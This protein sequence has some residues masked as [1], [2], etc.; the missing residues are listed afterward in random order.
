MGNYVLYEA[1]DDIATLTLN[2]PEKLNPI[3]IPLQEELR[4]ALARL[5]DDR[6]IRCAILTGAGRAFCVGADLS[7]MGADPS[8]QRSRGERS[9]DMMTRISNPIIMALRQLSVPVVAAVNGPAAGAGVGIALACDLVVA[10][11]SAYFYLPFM[12]RLGIIPDLG[13]TWFLPRLVGSARAMGMSL[14]G[15]RLTAEQAAAW[16]LIWSCV[17][18]E[19]LP[20]EAHTL[21]RRLAALPVHAVTE[22]RAALAASATNGLP[23]QLRYEATRQR[24]LLDGAPFAEGVAAFQEKREPKFPGRR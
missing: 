20:R 9:H 18:D 19:A 24:D 21:A 8:D 7:G 14:L 10:A 16:G 5:A 17:E 12:P 13:T 3:A 22:I 15:E 23:E 11:R 1:S 6:S 2:Y 4:D